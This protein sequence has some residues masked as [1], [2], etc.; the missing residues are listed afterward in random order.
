VRVS[1]GALIFSLIP[2]IVWV[3]VIHLRRIHLFQNFLQ[4]SIQ[5][6]V[7]IYTHVYIFMEPFGNVIWKWVNKFYYSST[8]L[9]F[10]SITAHN[11]LHNNDN[12]A[13][14]VPIGHTFF[15]S[16]LVAMYL[17]W[18]IIMVFLFLHTHAPFFLSF[19]FK[20]IHIENE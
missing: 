12:N 1:A 6:Q 8:V 20:Q 7:Q 14:Y 11:S 9:S 10:S 15:T 5:I 3:K 18:F 16:Y 19:L 2:I 13:E 17:I 4:F